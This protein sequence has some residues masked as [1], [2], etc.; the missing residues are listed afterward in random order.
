[1]FHVLLILAYVGTTMYQAY[2]YNDPVDLMD[3]LVLLGIGFIFVGSEIYKLRK[4]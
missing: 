2:M 3:I 1:M 4:V